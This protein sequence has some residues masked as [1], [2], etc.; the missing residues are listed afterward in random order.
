MTL[1]DHLD[2][3]GVQC[4]RAGSAS[5]LRTKFMNGGITYSMATTGELRAIIQELQL[6]DI[7]DAADYLGE[8]ATVAKELPSSVQRPLTGPQT[9]EHLAECDCDTCQGQ[10]SS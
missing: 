10:R 4:I 1:S 6:V 3:E 7:G 2:T 8:E 9:T 5:T